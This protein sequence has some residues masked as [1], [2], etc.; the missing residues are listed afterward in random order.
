MH[1]V[2]AIR[3]HALLPY[4][5]EGEMDYPMERYHASARAAEA[6][7]CA[8]CCKHQCTATVRV[9]TPRNRLWSTNEIDANGNLRC[10][11]P[12][13]L[14]VPREV[15]DKTPDKVHAPARPDKRGSAHAS[16]KSVPL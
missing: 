7:L 15:Q 10:I 2:L 6:M 14:S 12:K 11:R 1:L 16:I 8:F 5:V 13:W 3:P 4:C 9:Y